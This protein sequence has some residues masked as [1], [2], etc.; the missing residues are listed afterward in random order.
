MVYRQR[1]GR[2]GA[3]HA[4][5]SVRDERCGTREA[6]ELPAVLNLPSPWGGGSMQRA[7]F[8]S[9]RLLPPAR[10]FRSIPFLPLP[11]APF[12]P[13][14]SS[15]SRSLLSLLPLPPSSARSFRSSPF[16]PLPLAIFAP[17]PASLSR[18]LLSLL[19]RLPSPARSFNLSLSLPP[20]GPARLSLPPLVSVNALGPLFPFL[21]PLPPACNARCPPSPSPAEARRERASYQTPY[22]VARFCGLLRLHA[23]FPPPYTLRERGRGSLRLWCG[24]DAACCGL[25]R[26][27]RAAGIVLL[28]L[29]VVKKTQSVQV[30]LRRNK[31]Q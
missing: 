8:R 25:L 29:R 3:E 5:G 9:F 22:L 13:S 6:V 2:G 10:S 28:C 23:A 30:A 7:S 20:N 24:F 17:S 11:L 1:M 31:S 21:L 16:L 12:A 15:L 26:G 14:P 19:S 4:A 18:S 27:A